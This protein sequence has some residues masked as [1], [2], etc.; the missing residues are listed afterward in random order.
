[1]KKMITVSDETGKELNDHITVSVER[2]GYSITLPDGSVT[3]RAIFHLEPN[4]SLSILSSLKYQ[5]HVTPFM[6]KR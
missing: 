5:K 1:M 4:S 3:N 6:E 2:R